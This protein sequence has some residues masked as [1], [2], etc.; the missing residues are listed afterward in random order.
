MIKEKPVL[1][2]A[3]PYVPQRFEQRAITQLPTVDIDATNLQRVLL[4]LRLFDLPLCRYHRRGNVFSFSERLC[5]GTS[6]QPKRDPD[7]R[8]N[9]RGRTLYPPISREKTIPWKASS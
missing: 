1:S 5:A 9:H 6:E 3:L 2:Y 8:Y 4:I 7:T